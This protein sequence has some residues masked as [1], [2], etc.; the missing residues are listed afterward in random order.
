MAHQAWFFKLDRN[1]KYMF[2]DSTL[3]LIQCNFYIL[4]SLIYYTIPFL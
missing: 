1:L 4:L 3:L 2:E